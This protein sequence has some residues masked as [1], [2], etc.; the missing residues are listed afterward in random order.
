M[1]RLYY[2]GLRQLNLGKWRNPLTVAEGEKPGKLS[3]EAWKPT[4]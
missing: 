1:A 2:R 3:R 4:L